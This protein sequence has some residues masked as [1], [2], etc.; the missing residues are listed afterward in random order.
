MIEVKYKLKFKDIEVE[1]TRKEVQNLYDAASQALGNYHKINTVPA[2]K[3]WDIIGAPTY[4]S[5]NI[6]FLPSVE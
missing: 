6:S 3:P 4:S 5:G 2:I 1:L